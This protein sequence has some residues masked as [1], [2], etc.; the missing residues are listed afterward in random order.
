MKPKKRMPNLERAA[1]SLYTYDEASS[2]VGFEQSKFEL[3]QATF[4]RLKG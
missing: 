1:E 3:T 4:T 2:L